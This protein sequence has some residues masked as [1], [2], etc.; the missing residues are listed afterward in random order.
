MAADQDDHLVS[1]EMSAD[2]TIP[3]TD[4]EEAMIADDTNK[5]DCKESFR[6][7]ENDSDEDSFNIDYSQESPTAS[8]KTAAKRMTLPHHQTLKGSHPSSGSLNAIGALHGR[9][10]SPKIEHDSLVLCTP[11]I[12][13]MPTQNEFK[14]KASS[15]VNLRSHDTKNKQD[16]E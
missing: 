8:P 10:K 6:D 5:H 14:L 3:E 9:S 13:L 4:S 15:T 2:A 16:S 7:E 11:D 12:S 1:S